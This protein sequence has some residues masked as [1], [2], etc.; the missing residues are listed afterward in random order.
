[1]TIS[2]IKS[3]TFKTADG[4]C[5]A[6]IEFNRPERNNAL[7]PDLLREFQAVVDD[8][9]ASRAKVIIVAAKGNHFSTGGDIGE[10]ARQV[11]SSNGVKYARQLVQLLQETI[12]KMLAAPAIFIVA[13][14]GAITGGSSGF[15]FASDLAVIDETSFLQPY[16]REVG[17]GPD[18]GWTALLPEIIGARRAQTL[19]YKNQRLDAPQLLEFGLADFLVA[20]GESVQTAQKIAEELLATANVSALIAS[21]KLTWH[22]AKL[23][24]IRFKLEAETE[25]F[26]RLFQAPHMVETLNS[27]KPSKAS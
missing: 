3:S 5:G 25:E 27:F 12:Y 18:G 11:S 10:F 13:A 15:L 2:L 23:R 7:V 17:F 16:Y 22:P 4:G 26:I 8:A 21:K 20:P 14:Q 19:Q 6:L 24:E 1:M 9:L